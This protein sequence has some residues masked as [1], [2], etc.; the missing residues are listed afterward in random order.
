[1]KKIG[2]STCAIYLLT[3]GL[4]NSNIKVSFRLL[5]MAVLYVFTLYLHLHSQ[6]VSFKYLV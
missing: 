6:L 4:L 5:K 3:N 2:L 1:M